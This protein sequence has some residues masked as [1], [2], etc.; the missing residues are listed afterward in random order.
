MKKYRRFSASCPG[1]F[2]VWC[3]LRRNVCV[4]A[5]LHRRAL[6]RPRPQE[7]LW[8]GFDLGYLRTVGT[9]AP[10]AARRSGASLD[11]N[12]NQFSTKLLS[13]ESL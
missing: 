12:V 7:S 9:S 3:R 2:S 13:Q 11:I 6:D 8:V 1:Q 4:R 10:S 5:L